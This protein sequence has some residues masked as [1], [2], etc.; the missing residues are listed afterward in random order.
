MLVA[1][2][3]DSGTS[4]WNKG[5]EFLDNASAAP[6]FVPGICLHTS[7]TSH[8]ARKKRQASHQVHCFVHSTPARV[9]NSDHSH[10]VTLT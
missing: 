2:S 5:R 9:N 6:L 4:C 3:A 1:S 7:A 10:V 8:R